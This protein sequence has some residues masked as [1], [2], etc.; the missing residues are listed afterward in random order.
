MKE[1]I[2]TLYEYGFLVFIIAFIIE[3][4]RKGGES[5]NKKGKVYRK[6]VYSFIGVSSFIVRR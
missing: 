3:A 2:Q 4:L 6:V 1:A 5:Q